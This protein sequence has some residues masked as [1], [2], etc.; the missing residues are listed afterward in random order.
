MYGQQT[1]IQ[2][3]QRFKVGDFCFAKVRGYVEWP[4]YIVSIEHQHAW[5]KFFNSG[6]L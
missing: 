4:C 3:T 5:V 1:T 2:R 6:L